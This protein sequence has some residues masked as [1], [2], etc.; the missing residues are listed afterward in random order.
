MNDVAETGRIAREAARAASAPARAPAAARALRV[1]YLANRYPSVSHTFI[2][3]EI[4]AVEATG[5]VEVLRY[6]LQ[7]G[8]HA[9]VHEADRAEAARTRVV[10]DRGAAALVLAALGSLARQPARFASALALAVRIGWGS[11]RGLLR[12]FG[13]F[14]QACRLEAMLRE[15]GAE[16]LHAHFGTQAAAVAM[17]CRELGGVPYSLTI[18]GPLELELARLLSLGEKVA[19][20]AFVVAITDFCRSQIWRQSPAAHH[21]KVH[22]VGCGVDAAFL[23]APPAGLSSERRLVFVGRLSE[24]KAPGLLVDA[25]ARLRRDGLAFELVFVGDGELRPELEA[26]IAREGLQDCVRILGFSDE[27]AVRRWIAGARALVLPSFAE[28]LPVVLMEALALGRPVVATYIAGI[29]ELVE[30]GRSGWLVPAGSLDSLTAALREVLDAPLERLEA[31]G[32][33]GRA[34]VQ[35]RHDAA[36]NGRRLAG[37]FI[38]SARRR[39]AG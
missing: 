12:H 15:D 2:R 27:P 19:R 23:E 8:G 17:L 26:A 35:E 3:R 24:H 37:L 20:A 10:L 1:A 34:R 28:G 22:V 7:R 30:P 36:K 32:R 21:A 39:S 9:D 25:A 4:T 16:H 6:S 13:Y 11:D 38:S 14:A 31:M 18:H 33:A 5:E 29:P